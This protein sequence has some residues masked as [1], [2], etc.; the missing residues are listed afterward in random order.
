MT[1]TLDF[2]YAFPTRIAVITSGRQVDAHKRQ[3]LSPLM[4]VIQHSP[5]EAVRHVNTAKI[6]G[7]PYSNTTAVA[8]V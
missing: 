6:K 3:L 8:V 2:P 5:A 7:K 1:T 4:L